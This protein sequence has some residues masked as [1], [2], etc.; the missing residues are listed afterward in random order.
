LTSFSERGDEAEAIERRHTA[1]VLR[2]RDDDDDDDDDDDEEAD[3]DGSPERTAVSGV[4]SVW[5][6]VKKPLLRIGNKGA[7]KSHGNS[8][9]QLLE[10]HGAV[11]VKV[12]TNQFGSLDEAFEVLR[13]LTE[14]AG[15]DPGVEL[16]QARKLDKTILVGRA[17]TMEAIRVGDF[18]PSE[19]EEEED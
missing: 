16:L 6:Y 3:R 8:L 14:E 1:T 4:E 12:N 5:R 7:S 2:R 18:P 9:R 11:K 17:G 15:A 10:D 13:K 19:E